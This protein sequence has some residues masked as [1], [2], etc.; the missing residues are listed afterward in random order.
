MPTD[1]TTWACPGPSSSM[2]GALRSQ[3]GGRWQRQLSELKAHMSHVLD[4]HSGPAWWESNYH[5]TAEKLRLGVVKGE[6]EDLQRGNEGFQPSP[7]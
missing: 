3:A 6:P 5:F 2:Q 4:S 1:L 7:E